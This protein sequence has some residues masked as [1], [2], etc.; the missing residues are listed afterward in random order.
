MA[1]VIIVLDVVLVLFAFFVIKWARKKK[2]KWPIVLIIAAIVILTMLYLFVVFL[3][4][5]N[6]SAVYFTLTPKRGYTL[7]EMPWECKELLSTVSLN[8]KGQ[9]RPMEFREY[10]NLWLL[11]GAKTTMY[12]SSILEHPMCHNFLL[13][14]L[15]AAKE[16]RILVIYDRQAKKELLIIRNY[17]YK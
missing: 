5:A 15:A 9:H 17:N 12:D 10:G 3:A 4:A 6:R 1:M 2:R 7:P 16:R 13:Q 11:D 8:P 14:R